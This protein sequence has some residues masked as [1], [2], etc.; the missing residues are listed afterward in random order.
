MRGHNLSTIVIR[1]QIRGRFKQDNEVILKIS[2]RIYRGQSSLFESVT[3]VWERLASNI[4]Q[5]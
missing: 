5:E 2:R 3:R 1:K 4:D